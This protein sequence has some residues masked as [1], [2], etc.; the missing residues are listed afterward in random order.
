MELGAGGRGFCWLSGGCLLLA[1]LL[2]ELEGVVDV[3]VVVGVCGARVGGVVGV[4][5]RRCGGLG[6]VEFF[7]E[8]LICDGVLVDVV[9]GLVGEDCLEGGV[10]VAVLVGELLGG[11]VEGGVD[12]V[13]RWVGVGLPE[14]VD[15]R[16]GVGEGLL[17]VVVELLGWEAVGVVAGGEVGVG[18]GCV[19]LVGGV[20]D[21]LGVGLSGV[22]AVVEGGD[23]AGSVLLE[24]LV[25]LGGVGDAAGGDGVG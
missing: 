15:L 25:V 20:E 24:L 22:V 3:V 12:V 1:V 10:G 14:V 21:F 8:G 11:A 17:G 6:E 23:A 4:G 9:G 2:G 13:L 16:P 7:E 18:G 19:V 5:G